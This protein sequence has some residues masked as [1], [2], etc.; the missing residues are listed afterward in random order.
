MMVTMM[1]ESA[2]RLS[3]H[4]LPWEESDTC[5]NKQNQHSD[6]D[7]DGGDDD[8]DDDV[9]DDDAA[10]AAAAADDRFSLT[11]L[12]PSPGDEYRLLWEESDK[13]VKKQNQH[14]DSDDDGGDDDN[15]YNNDKDGKSNVHL[16][17]N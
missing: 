9:D 13:C 11:S 16:N 10:A 3:S 17:S 7:G 5:E 14:S 4:R 2:S 8:D 6:S 15:G 1:N 12:W